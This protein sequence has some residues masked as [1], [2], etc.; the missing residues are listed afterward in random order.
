MLVLVGQSHDCKEGHSP[1]ASQPPL[2]LPTGCFC[3]PWMPSFLRKLSLEHPS[4]SFLPMQ[5]IATNALSP[6]LSK[7]LASSALL[8]SAVL[9]ESS[10]AP[11]LSAQICQELSHS[12]TLQLWMAS[13]ISG[14]FPGGHLVPLATPFLPWAPL[15]LALQI[16]EVKEPFW[17]WSRDITDLRV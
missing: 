15:E 6:S 16:S 13:Q 17:S 11:G 12:K 8:Q 9:E 14:L 1:W 2:S 7:L 3:S 10:S 5:Y 4:K